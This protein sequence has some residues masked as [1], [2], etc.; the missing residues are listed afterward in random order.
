MST[1]QMSSSPAEGGSAKFTAVLAEL[2]VAS[3]SVG[4]VVSG[5]DVVSQRGNSGVPVE[6]QRH[7]LTRPGTA[8]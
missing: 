1:T 6:R 8:R 5:H 3:W 4:V 2:L 7:R